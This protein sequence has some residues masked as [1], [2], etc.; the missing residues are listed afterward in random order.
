MRKSGMAIAQILQYKVCFTALPKF[1]AF[2]LSIPV[3]LDTRIVHHQL[4]TMD[5]RRKYDIHLHYFEA[6]KMTSQA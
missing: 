1:F 4:V 2:G 3:F 6:T 5:V